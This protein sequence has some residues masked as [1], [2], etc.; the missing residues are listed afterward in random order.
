MCGYQK[1]TSHREEWRPGTGR[2]K[3]PMGLVGF[4]SPRRPPHG[5]AGLRSATYAPPGITSM[6]LVFH[7]VSF[8]TMCALQILCCDAV[9][10]ALSSACDVCEAS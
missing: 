2:G 1:L 6:C 4:L 3:D 7:V 8:T 5:G 9:V 10:G